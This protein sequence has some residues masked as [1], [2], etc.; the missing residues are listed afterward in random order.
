MSW[1]CDCA[2]ADNRRNVEVGRILKFL[3]FGERRLSC[4]SLKTASSVLFTSQGGTPCTRTRT[5]YIQL[6]LFLSNPFNKSNE[7]GKSC[8]RQWIESI[9]YEDTSLEWFYQLLPDSMFCLWLPERERHQEWFFWIRLKVV[10]LLY[11][12]CFL[13]VRCSREQGL[14]RTLAAARHS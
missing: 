4:D 7:W 8:K 14:R 1:L 13:A 10:L 12:G 3:N 6:V 9:R 11:I 2:Q 5:H